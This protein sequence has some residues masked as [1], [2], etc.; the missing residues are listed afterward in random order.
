MPENSHRYSYCAQISQIEVRVLIGNK[1]SQSDNDR[2]WT[3][4]F[5]F[6]LFFTR[7]MVFTAKNKLNFI[8]KLHGLDTE[9]ILNVMNASR[10]ERNEE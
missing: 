1:E 6:V 9:Y 7:E 2:L 10:I 3:R 8:F 4:I 5:C